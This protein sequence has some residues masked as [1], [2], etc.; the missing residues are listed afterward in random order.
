MRFE[1]LAFVSLKVG[2]FWV[3]TPCCSVCQFQT[4][5]RIVVASSAITVVLTECQEWHTQYCIGVSQKNLIFNLE[6]VP[7]RTELFATQGW[8]RDFQF[9]AYVAS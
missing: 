8:L 9:S 4:F 1:V 5:W 2:V 7:L 6:A 3:L